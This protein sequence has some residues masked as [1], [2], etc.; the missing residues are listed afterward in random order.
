MIMMR[1]P[2]KPLKGTGDKEMQN[3]DD[4]AQDEDD[5]DGNEDDYGDDDK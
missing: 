1:K 5:D 2:L 3:C 4:D